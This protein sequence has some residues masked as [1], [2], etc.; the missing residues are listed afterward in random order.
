M[1][2][3]RG[4][5][6]AVVVLVPAALLVAIVIGGLAA[7]MPAG[8]YL[9]LSLP[10]IG[11]G[12]LFF[13]WSLRDEKNAGMPGLIHA[14]LLTLVALSV[15]WP[16]YIFIH[17]AGLPGVNPFTLLTMGM[18]AL[19]LI[20]LLA[21]PA[22]SR[23]VAEV[24]RAGGSVGVLVLIWFAWRIIATAFGKYPLAQEIELFKEI[25]YIGSFFLFA[26]ALG[27]YP[28]GPRDVVRVLVLCGLVAAGVGLVEGFMHKN[29][30]VGLISMAGA[31]GDTAR[32][33]ANI[34]SDKVRE[35][36]FRAQS[37]FDHPIVFA[38]FVAALLPLALYCAAHE[39]GKLWRFVGA[40][41]VPV[42]L[43]AIAK[44]GSRAGI[45]SVAVAFAAVGFV[46][47]LRALIYGRVSKVL[48]I[49]ALP[50][51]LMLIV[52]AVAVISELAG[53]RS[54]HEISSTNTRLFMLRTGIN[55]LWDSPILGFGHGMSVL[56]AGVQ[57]AG[58]VWTI[59]NYFLT[60]ALDYGYVGLLLFW[61]LVTWFGVRLL[62]HS[63]HN[64]G[65]CGALSG[66]VL[67]GVISLTAAFSALSIYQNMSM[68]WLMFG[69]GFYLLRSVPVFANAN[70][71]RI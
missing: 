68:L 41:A 3:S 52:V 57:G 54:Q 10:F 67:A 42:A 11:L 56:K 34:A 22:Y 62:R 50:A 26:L 37:T 43:A 19:V 6:F 12:V 17:K 25:V 20:H 69:I 65:E 59:D 16:R 24:F 31:D 61:G 58:G 70:G 5:Q 64:S 2:N 32:T 28:N 47:W 7:L 48:A 33:L 55:A 4:F 71:G 9:R 44:S 46:W 51:F 21:V 49:V 27:A 38:Q 14:G 23:R 8:V 40:L 53:G 30:F 18:L 13:A 1:T 45:V 66:A 63:V 60:L 35:G 39:K 36:A 15:L 29:P